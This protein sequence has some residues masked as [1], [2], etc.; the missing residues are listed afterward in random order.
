MPVSSGLM[1]TDGLGVPTKELES[2]V[3]E[4]RHSDFDKSVVLFRYGGACGRMPQS[5][6]TTAAQ[7]GLTV[8]EV[9][10]IERRV[11][12]R[13]SGPP[14]PERFARFQ[15]KVRLLWAMSCR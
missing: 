8:P 15:E 13:A 9:A 1:G 7:F 5:L 2:L 10:F 12:G 14:D 11:L 6:M 4:S 3:L